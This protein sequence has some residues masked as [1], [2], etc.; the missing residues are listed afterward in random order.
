MFVIGWFILAIIVG[1]VAGSRGRLGIMWFLLALV[2]SPLLALLLLVCLPQLVMVGG[3]RRTW[4]DVQLMAMGLN[5]AGYRMDEP[6]GEVTPADLQ[7]D[8]ERRTF[9]ITALV[10]L[11]VVVSIAI[12]SSLH[13][14]Q[15]APHTYK[16]DHG[17]S[18]VIDY[19]VEPVAFKL[20][21]RHTMLKQEE[22]TCKAAYVGAL[23]ADKV[24]VC[25]ATQGVSSLYVGDKSYDCNRR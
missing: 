22:S 16:C 24:E 9:R 2:I 7:R 15:A 18:F 8:L 14:S 4:T 20:G 10:V 21:T 23:G 6:P 17:T 19:D 5:S 12:L 11:A 25:I 13:G 1:I 3:K